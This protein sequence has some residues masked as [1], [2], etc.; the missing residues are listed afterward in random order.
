[1]P[2]KSPLSPEELRAA[3]E[4]FLEIHIRPRGWTEAR[5]EFFNAMIRRFPYSQESDAWR[6]KRRNLDAAF[7]GLHRKAQHRGWIEEVSDRW[8]LTPKGLDHLQGRTVPVNRPVSATAPSVPDDHD[9]HL[10]GFFGELRDALEPK[11]YVPSLEPWKGL[12][13]PDLDEG[14]AHH[15]LFRDAAYHLRAMKVAKA[16]N[17][18]QAFHKV[19]GL[20][21][22]RRKR[23]AECLAGCARIVTS[24]HVSWADE[25]SPYSQA[26]QTALDIILVARADGRKEVEDL[27]VDVEQGVI[28]RA[29]NTIFAGDVV[30]CRSDIEAAWIQAKTEARR[31]LL[32]S[33]RA[34]ARLATQIGKEKERSRESIRELLERASMEGEGPLRALVRLT[35]E[36]ARTPPQSQVGSADEDIELGFLSLLRHEAALDLLQLMMGVLEG[37]IGRFEVTSRPPPS[38][39]PIVIVPRRTDA[40]TL[41]PAGGAGVLS[42]SPDLT[43][44]N[45]IIGTPLG[46]SQ[47]T[48]SVPPGPPSGQMPT[49]FPLAT[50]GRSDRPRSVSRARQKSRSRAERS[51]Q[52]VVAGTS[53]RHTKGDSSR[54]K[55]RSRKTLT[56]RRVRS[57]PGQT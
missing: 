41:V 26:A 39:P 57:R 35:S 15:P 30:G 10:Y 24:K 18:M 47:T 31:S 25:R 1:M 22:T 6:V 45:D 27:T 17:P 16:R 12:E 19:A 38:G 36:P 33:Y 44:L 46:P 43:W 5:D 37:R 34:V 32:R 7:E 49:S 20:S 56:S 13:S 55:R 11:G 29:N 54:N 53:T 3:E 40:G 23:R 50:P 8:R 51:T 4:F 2:R 21:R 48:A 14:I 52:Q 9:R 42:Q 28:R